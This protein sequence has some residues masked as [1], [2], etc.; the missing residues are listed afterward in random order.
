MTLDFEEDFWR[1]EGDEI[2]R[3]LGVVVVRFGDI[4]EGRGGVMVPSGDE[5]EERES[6]GGREEVE[7]SKESLLGLL[8]KQGRDGFGVR[9]IFKI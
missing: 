9:V 1:E 5:V 7:V 4:E 8:R 6:E 2:S 3:G